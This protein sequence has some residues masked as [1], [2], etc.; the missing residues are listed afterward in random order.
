MQEIIYSINISQVDPLWSGV[1][2]KLAVFTVPSKA[3]A[4]SV[5]CAPANLLNLRGS[6]G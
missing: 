1:K 6:G 4:C 3:L 2:F 5:T